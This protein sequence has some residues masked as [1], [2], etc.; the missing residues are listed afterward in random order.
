MQGWFMLIWFGVSLA[1]LVGSWSARTEV[2]E[3]VWHPMA[4]LLFPLS[5]AAFM[6]DWL[7]PAAQKVILY[8]PMVHGVELLREG[9]FG[10]AVHAHYDI[11]YLAFI[12]LCL[13]L[14]GLAMLREAGRR[15]IPE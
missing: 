1:I 15:V 13:N 14:L 3:K 5:G 2:I 7:P 4:Y 11:A 9:Y 12:C 6:V 8:L 10:S